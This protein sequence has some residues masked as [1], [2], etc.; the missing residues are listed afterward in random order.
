MNNIFI[1]PLLI[2]LQVTLIGGSI[3]IICAIF[4]A[5]IMYKYDFRFKFLLEIIFLLPIV[6][7]PSV[8]GFLILMMVGVNSPLY[9]LVEFIFGQNIIFTKIAA[10]IAAAIVAFPIMYQASKIAFNHID[11]DIISAA[12]LDQASQLQI[13]KLIILPLSKYALVSGMVLAYA[14]AF[15]E[16]GASLMVAGNIPGK[17][18]TLPIAIYNAMAI[19]D[20]TTAAIY[21]AIMLFCSI[22]FLLLTKSLANKEY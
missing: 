5:Y 2:S 19:N 9:P 11:D 8:I 7:P 12:M 22:S 13:F 16:F 3:A 15:G 10:I 21:V 4:W 17:T 6:L 1:S 20:R 18:Q 14:R